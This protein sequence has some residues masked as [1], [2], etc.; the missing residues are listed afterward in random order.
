[1]TSAVY[2]E[3]LAQAEE[4]SNFMFRSDIDGI[5][6]MSIDDSLLF[7]KKW[8]QFQFG[9]GWGQIVLDIFS[10]LTLKNFKKGGW[11]VVGT[12]NS[13][14][15]YI[16]GALADIFMLVG[17]MRPNVG[18]TFNFDDCV[19]KQ[20]V[21]CEEFFLDK[22]DFFTIETLKDVLSGNPATV[23]IKNMKSMSLKPTPWLFISNHQNFPFADTSPDNP[24][25]ERFYHCETK[26]YNGWTETTRQY[27]LHPYAWIILFKKF[28]LL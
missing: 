19:G 5:K 28:R 7:L 21:R 26:V 27:R 17:F 9:N 12:P 4:P 25:P 14:K 11:S 15:S 2:L 8:L 23:K 10:W 1:M 16:F 18:Y 13:G 20:I 22:S 6:Y 24:W 3:Y